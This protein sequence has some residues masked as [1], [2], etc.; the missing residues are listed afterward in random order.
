MPD[1]LDILANAAKESIAEGYYKSTVQVSGKPLSLRKVI[2]KCQR[3]PIISEIK[4]ASPSSGTLRKDGQLAEIARDMG[5]GGAVG[6]SILTEP[7][8]FKGNTEYVAEV[9][10][11][12]RIPILMKDIILSPIQVEAASRIRANA[13]LL[14]QALFE[15]GYCEKNVQAMIEYCHSK[16]LEVLLET[17]TEDEFLSAVKTDADLIGIN[18]RDLMTL[19]VDIEVTKRVLEKC[20]VEDKI[21]V[22]ESGIESAEDIRSLR[23]W[24]ARAFL[25][26]TA[27]MKSS[28]IRDKVEELVKAL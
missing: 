23:E 26:G 3:A 8:H 16:G 4:F 1:Y 9:R 27:I 22:T 11:Q 17:H 24:G 5:D 10:A 12:V 6:I 21:I 20:D 18:N 25:V 7:R 2:L 15:R 28:S 14:I 13:V 19:K